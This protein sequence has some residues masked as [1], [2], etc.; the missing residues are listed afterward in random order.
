MAEDLKAEK[1]VRKLAARADIKLEKSPKNNGAR[2][3]QMLLPDGRRLGANGKPYGLSLATVESYLCRNHS[4]VLPREQ[5]N[6]L[7]DIVPVAKTI[8]ES[9]DTA[10]TLRQLFYQLVSRQII[11]NTSLDYDYLSKVTAEQRRYG[12]FP[13]LVDQTAHILAPRYFH[14]P[15]DSIQHVRDIYRVDRTEG[16]E[17]SLYLGVEKS[18][19]QNQL[20]SWFGRRMALPILAL[21]GYAS[22]SYCDNI[23]ADVAAS[24]RPGVLIYAGDHDA[25]GDDIYRDL[26]ER[27]DCWAKTYR[28]A[29][30]KEQVQDYDLPENPGKDTDTRT[31]AF[32]ERHGY[33][34][35]VQ[36][37]LDALSPTVLRELYRNAIDQHW[38]E[39][40]FDAAME[41]E[42]QERDQLDRI[43]LPE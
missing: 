11:E 17:V 16:Q 8:V 34:E 24:G 36:V 33:T 29:L 22:Q 23:A 21:G 15:L 38:D 4:D 25:S 32:M 3:F 19:I 28:I 7:R 20:W 41:R 10:V 27:T 35:N 31:G 6:W 18:G 37:E 43:E 39:D 30:T 9:Y 40:A 26:L 14:S 1:R 13:A 2:T 5:R 12:L 42:E